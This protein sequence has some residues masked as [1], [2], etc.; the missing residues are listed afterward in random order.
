[1]SGKWLNYIFWYIYLENGVL[2]IKF[3][4]L[5]NKLGRKDCLGN[6]CGWKIKLNDELFGN[7]VCFLKLS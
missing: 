7:F 5:E 2:K 3:K 1:M 6:N 4:I